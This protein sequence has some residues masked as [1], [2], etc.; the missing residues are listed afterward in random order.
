MAC[1]ILIP[2]PEIEPVPSA[3][4]ERSSSHCTTREIPEKLFFSDKNEDILEAIDHIEI[5]FWLGNLLALPIPRL[6]WLGGILR[7]QKMQET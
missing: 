4:G 2:Q 5:K 1:R 3:V 6:R 7:I